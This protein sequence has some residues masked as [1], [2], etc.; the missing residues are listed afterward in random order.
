MKIVIAMLFLVLIV[1]SS[2]AAIIA[3]KSIGAAGGTLAETPM[4]SMMWALVIAA[5]AGA[6]MAVGGV[7]SVRDVMIIG[8]VPFSGIMAL[9]VVSSDGAM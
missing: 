4:H 1:A 8:A 6:V 9:M 2:S 7:N 5:C 3:I